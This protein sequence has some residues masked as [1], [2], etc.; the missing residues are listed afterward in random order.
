M[1]KDVKGKKNQRN[2]SRMLK[3]KKT[4]IGLRDSQN[5]S[6]EMLLLIWKIALAYYTVQENKIFENCL[7]IKKKIRQFHHS[8]I[9]TWHDFSVI[10]F[11]F[12]FFK[13]KDS[14][15]REE[16]KQIMEGKLYERNRGRVCQLL[17]DLWVYMLVSQYRRR[18]SRCRRPNAKFHTNSEKEK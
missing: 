3:L 4:Q 9:S 12:F 1:L 6:S 14:K 2:L 11:S 7:S 13:I 8:A 15:A 10:G 5:L 18:G 16:E 17:V